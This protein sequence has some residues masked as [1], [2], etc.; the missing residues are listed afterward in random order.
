L[1]HVPRR[2][3]EQTLRARINL[4]DAE[5]AVLFNG[6]ERPRIKDGENG[7]VQRV[8]DS[9]IFTFDAPEAIDTLRLRFDPDYSRLSISDNKKMRVFAM[10]LH[11]GKDFEPVRVA[12]SIVRGLAVYADGREIW[13]T[14]DNY[15]SLLKIPLHC[16]AREIRVEWLATSGASDVHLFAADLI[17]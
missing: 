15:L 5:R 9:L 7:V 12:S 10:K 17:D 3:S 14:E 13:R 2:V 11:T 1:P 8:G 16:T 4:S 6:V